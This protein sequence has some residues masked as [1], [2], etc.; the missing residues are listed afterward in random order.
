M[1]GISCHK[2]AKIKRYCFKCLGQNS[3]GLDPNHPQLKQ[4][5]YKLEKHTQWQTK[6]SE[7]AVGKIDRV[8]IWDSMPFLNFHIKGI[9]SDQ[10]HHYT[11]KQARQI[12]ELTIHHVYDKS[13]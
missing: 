13:I 12:I 2:T 4:S 10:Y 8:H 1:V 7:I 9:A 11:K 3:K 6:T 5:T